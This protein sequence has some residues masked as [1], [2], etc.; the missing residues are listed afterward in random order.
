MRDLLTGIPGWRSWPLFSGRP[1]GT[2][3]K[4]NLALLGDAA[5]AMLPFLAQGGAMAI[6]DA[7]VLTA[8]LTKNHMDIPSRLAAYSAARLPRVTRVQ[9]E[10]VKNGERYHWSGP[11]AGLRNIGMRLLGGKDCSTATIGSMGGAREVPAICGDLILLGRP[12]IPN[13]MWAWRN[14]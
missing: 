8:C 5:H 10:A 7:A 12:S 14:W 6:E 3:V 2:I 1:T 11:K 4:G 9:A 13:P